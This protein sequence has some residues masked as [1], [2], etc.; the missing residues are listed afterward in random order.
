MKI[1]LIFI[2][3]A[4]LLFGFGCTTSS[5]IDCT[6][7]LPTKNPYSTDSSAHW[8]GWQS[9]QSDVA[10]SCQG[11]DKAFVEGC[12]VYVAQKKAYDKCIVSQK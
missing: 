4:I 10:T 5:P 12:N 6:P 9:A 2:S 11:N 8:A 7:L 1:S 3:F